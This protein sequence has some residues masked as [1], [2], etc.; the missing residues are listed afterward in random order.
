MA[1]ELQVNV[2]PL[3]K[4]MEAILQ[5]LSEARI[6]S[7]YRKIF[8]GKGLEFLEFR[9]YRQD[10]DSSRIDWKATL[11]A[12][13]PLIKVFKEERDLDVYILLDVSNSMI[14]GSTE[15]LKS[16]YSAEIVAAISHI[17][18]STGDKAGLLM[19]S[20]RI[21]KVIPPINTNYQYYA[22]LKACVDGNLYGG[23]LDFDM[24]IKYV[25]N[26]A[27]RESLLIIVSDFFGL[28]ENWDNS[29]KIASIKFDVIGIM[30]RDI[31][32]E[33]LPRNIGKVLVKDPFSDREILIDPY[34]EAES[35][36][37]YTLEKKEQIKRAFIKYDSDFIEV[38]TNED[39]V[40]PFLT[41]LERR[42]IK[43]E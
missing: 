10:D 11:K 24:A 26:I 16:E 37:A 20:D 18:L 5:K 7:K 41:L 30:V 23:G 42:E 8:K 29:L 27:K 14:F 4:K 17:V 25:M 3:I 9:E 40:K 32:D 38:K 6:M 28:N 1:K 12:N 13:K 35:Y 19:F 31:R 34:L 2:K 43:L 15:K 33:E 22:I 21:K 36:R 39:F